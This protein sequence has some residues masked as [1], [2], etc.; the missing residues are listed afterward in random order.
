MSRAVWVLIALVLSA[1]TAAAE[2]VRTTRSTKV[3]KRTG[4]QSEVVTKVAKGKTLN[5]VAKQGRWLKVRVNGRTGWVTQSSVVSLEARD[6]PRNTR[7]RPFVDGR[8]T[9]RGWGG[10]AP[11]DRV[12]GDA[13]E[14]DDETGRGSDDDGGGEDDAAE[15]DDD[16]KPARGKRARRT[17]DDD[18]DDGGDDEGDDDEGDDD[19]GDDDEG[20]DDGDDIRTVTVTAKKAKLYPRASKKSKATLTVRRGAQLFVLG[21]H[22]SG[23]WIRV[24][25]EDGVAG[26]IATDA[27]D[28]PDGGRRKPRVIAAGARLG[29]ASVGGKFTSNAAANPNASPPADYGFGSTAVSLAIGG[30]IAFAMKKDYYVGAG[31][32]YLGCV[33]TP[34]IRYASGTMAEDIGFKTHDIDV[35]LIAGYDFHKPN[36]MTAWARVGYHYGVFSVGN[37]ENIASIPSETFSGPT[38]GTALRIPGLTKKIGA[39]AALDVVIPGKRK[40]TAGNTDGTQTGAKAA[41]LELLGTYAWQGAWRF[42]GAYQFGYAATSWTGNSE[43]VTGATAARRVDLSHVLTVGLGRDF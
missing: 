14:D 18:D 32:E 11:D 30:E 1:G 39:E 23:K 21:E 42:N 28:D 36:G 40:Q 2:R 12:G 6:L 7:R 20:D 38:V 16:A 8:S 3:F 43:R 26:W 5:V 27:V 34:G 31:L 15:D 29:F 22:D 4:E 24:E 35:R 37:L 17:S 25:D 13:I 9:R 19:E 41:T 33:A 10:G